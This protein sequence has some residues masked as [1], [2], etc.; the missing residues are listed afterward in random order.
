MKLDNGEIL[1]TGRELPRI[2]TISAESPAGAE[3]ARRSPRL[4]ARSFLDHAA[5]PLWLAPASPNE[6]PTPPQRSRSF[7]P[8][9]VLGA[10]FVRPA[11]HDR[12]RIAVSDNAVVAG[13]RSSDALR[14]TAG[15]GYLNLG[16][17]D[18]PGFGPNHTTVSVAFRQM[19]KP[20][21]EPPLLIHRLASVIPRPM[22]GTST[23]GIQPLGSTTWRKLRDGLS[24]ADGRVVSGLFFQIN[25]AQHAA[26]WTDGVENP[27]TSERHERMVDFSQR[28]VGRGR[29]RRD[30]TGNRLHSSGPQA[31]ELKTLGTLG[32]DPD[33][34]RA[35]SDDGN[36]AVGRRAATA[37]LFAGFAR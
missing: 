27:A 5:C 15:G 16:Y 21:W 24:P 6:I 12:R 1:A 3:C 20:S 19:V 14:W 13:E 4:V 30:D 11:G 34:V 18:S 31:V 17:V 2:L 9:L 36:V 37:L 28:R 25:S 26:V 8:H 33:I 35:V 23:N 7:T 10:S 29:Y 32:P 22:S